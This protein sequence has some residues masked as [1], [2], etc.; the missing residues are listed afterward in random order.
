MADFYTDED[1]G[2]LLARFLRDHGHAVTRTVD[3]GQA[4]AH[5]ADQ[6]AHAATHGL[7]L[8][9]HNGNHFRTLHDVWQRWLIVGL[10]AHSGIIVVPQLR[11]ERLEKYGYTYLTAAQVIADLLDSGQPLTNALYR[12]HPVRGW[13]L[14]SAS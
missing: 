12:W 3:S 2:P 10:P 1:V 5:D 9:T 6:L 11:G 4:G 7:I 13:V 14:N 8:I